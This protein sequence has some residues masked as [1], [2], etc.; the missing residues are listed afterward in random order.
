[1]VAV[2]DSTFNKQ[3]Q[4]G[5]HLAVART[6]N[7]C[8]ATGCPFRLIGPSEASGSSINGVEY[9]QQAQVLRYRTWRKYN[10]WYVHGA[11]ALTQ[12]Q[13]CWHENGASTLRPR[14][15]KSTFHLRAAPS[16]TSSQGVTTVR[17]ARWRPPLDGDDLAHQQ[18]LLQG[19]CLHI[20]TRGSE[21]TPCTSTR[22]QREAGHAMHWLESHHPRL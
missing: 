19:T 21:T 6:S 17:E 3:Q 2:G 20:S 22:G 8:S 10:S 15:H 13:Q 9:S 5:V 11:S 14:G 1:M 4:Q 12:H 16:R 18:L 7:G